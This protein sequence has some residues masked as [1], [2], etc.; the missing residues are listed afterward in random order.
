[1]TAHSTGYDLAKRVIDMCVALIALALL[2]PVIA[3]VAVLVA[4]GLGR[5][6]LFR[7]ARAGRAGKPFTLVKFRTMRDI[8]P[9]RGLISDAD[10][11]TPLGQRLRS[12]SLDELPSLWNVVKGDMSLVG[13][14]PLPTQYLN[15]YSPTEARRHDV[16][17]GLT[18]LAQVRGR[19][20]LSWPAKFAFDLQYVERRSLGLDL[21]IIVETVRTVVRRTGIAADG[22]ATAPEVLGSHASSGMAKR[23]ADA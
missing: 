4:S 14:R 10:R 22:E 7:Q 15:R 8:D 9:A 5:P 12:T 21:R 23:G 1:M 6:V 16:L 17:P 2:S 3:I 20:A 11:L 18:G 13:P 19:N